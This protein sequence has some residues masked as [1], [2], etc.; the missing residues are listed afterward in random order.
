MEDL[1]P[2]LQNDPNYLMAIGL[3]NPQ[4]AAGFVVQDENNQ[5]G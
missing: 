2:E 5:Q 1:N 3:L 4:E